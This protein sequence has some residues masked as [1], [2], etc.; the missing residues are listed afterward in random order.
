MALL[1][2]D[3]VAEKLNVSR[4]TVTRWCRE[5]T[6]DAR[7]VHGY[8]RI[9]GVGL[10]RKQQEAT[11]KTMKPGTT[12]R[13][14]IVNPEKKR[15]RTRNMEEV[16]ARADK[17][18]EARRAVVAAMFPNPVPGQVLDFVSSW[19]PGVGYEE[20]MKQARAYLMMAGN[21]DD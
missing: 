11:R 5:G 13:A 21:K 4:K 18:V 1:T 20:F 19:L 8:W 14:F 17:M 9:T 10:Q 3:E 6:I 12:S 7:K 15:V 2:P 16:H